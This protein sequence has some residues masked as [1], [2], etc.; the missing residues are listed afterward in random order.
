MSLVPAKC[1]QCGGEIE[2]DNTH[3]AGI[4]KF[5]GTPFVTE[6]VINNYS[7]NITNNNVFIGATVN[8]PA[9]NVDNLYKTARRF[10]KD[11]N[12]S[13]ALKYYSLILENDPTSW[14][15]YF[16]CTYYKAASA[17]KSQIERA[18]ESIVIC[19]DTVFDMIN[20]RENDDI[21]KKTALEDITASCLSLA[22]SLH[23]AVLDPT[24]VNITI[25]EMPNH[26][27]SVAKTC[28]II[29]TI[30]YM[31]GDK[32]E[33]NFS[34]MFNQ[35]IDLSLQAW[36]Q[37]VDFHSDCSSNL[38][39]KQEGYKII[40]DY[41]HK[42]KKYEPTYTPPSLQQNSGSGGCYIATA[43]YGSYDCPEVWTLRRFRD[44]TLDESWYGKLFIRLYY[45]VSPKLVKWF[46]DCK[47]FKMPCKK[48]LDAVVKRLN[49]S[50]VENTK[51]N[52]K[53]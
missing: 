25:A 53:Y 24:D 48:Y 41:V 2:V 9:P 35:L 6:K 19:L 29:A 20:S 26:I 44:Y 23:S 52:D 49:A 47:W 3:E 7:T 30:G 43:V 15:A 22:D 10:K 50:G 31:L 8:M 5:C 45:A 33:Q 27:K 1:T 36:K 28:L 37:G 42:I 39:N 38:P 34:S 21:E 4:C 51:Y 18:A 13:E 14:E 17:P 11:C 40:D 46:G 16:Y 12:I 32:I